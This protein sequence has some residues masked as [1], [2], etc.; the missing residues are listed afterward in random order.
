MPV[1]VAPDGTGAIQRALSGLVFQNPR[2][3]EKFLSATATGAL[4][5]VLD[6]A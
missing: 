1:R 4:A 3:P 6:R 5:I 2:R